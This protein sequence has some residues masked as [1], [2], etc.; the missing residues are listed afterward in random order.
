MFCALSQNYQPFWK[1]N[2]WTSK[3]SKELE[4]GIE[5]LVGQTVFKLWIKAVKVL[6]ESITQEPLVLPK[7]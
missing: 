6:F 5:I 3:L 7:F 1:N 2:I 4:N